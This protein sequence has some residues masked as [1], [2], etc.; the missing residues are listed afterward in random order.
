MKDILSK[1]QKEFFD[2]CHELVDYHGNIDCQ[3]ETWLTAIGRGNE[4]NNWKTLMI[5]GDI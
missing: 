3:L 1:S 2:I 5:K 4:I